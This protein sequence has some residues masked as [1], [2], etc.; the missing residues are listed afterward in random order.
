MKILI[1]GGAGFLGLNIAK[2]LHK[3]NHRVHLLDRSFQQVRGLALMAKMSGLHQTDCNNIEEIM[4]VIDGEQVECVLN[5]AS[6]MLPASPFEIFDDELRNTLSPGFRLVSKLACTKI[7]YVYM[8]SGGTVYGQPEGQH[9]GEDDPKN[10][11]SL[12]GLSKVFF[13]QFIG[14]AS[15]TSGLNYL[16]LRPSNPYGF[17]QNP[18]KKQGLIAVVTDKILNGEDVQIWGDGSV[19][20]DYIWVEDLANAV[21]ALLERNIW[22]ETFNIGSGLGHSVNEIIRTIEDVSG[23]AARCHY[24]ASRATDV[25]RIVLDVNRLKSAINFEPTMLRSGIEQYIEGLRLATA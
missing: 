10:P 3:A 12:Y 23:V 21:S 19:V 9:V 16:I 17:F 1:I 13:E 20:R 15:R 7:K 24:Q 11:I 6:G 25:S 22:N 8:S 5:L 2:A 4:A 14:Y 18:H